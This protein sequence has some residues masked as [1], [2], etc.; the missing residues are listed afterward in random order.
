MRQNFFFRSFCKKDELVTILQIVNARK[1]HK[2]GKCGAHQIE[3][4]TFLNGINSTN[5]E[6]CS[7]NGNTSNSCRNVATVD[8]SANCRQRKKF[9][10]EVS[11]KK[12]ATESVLQSRCVRALAQ[13][14]KV[15]L[16]LSNCCT[17][18]YYVTPNNNNN[19]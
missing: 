2:C 5:A 18:M 17:T 6:C 11:W 19:T 8:W 1:K 15:T 14:C 12:Y 16:S 9:L 10:C 3:K 4:A 13:D 7:S